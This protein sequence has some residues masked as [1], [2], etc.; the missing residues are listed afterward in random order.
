MRLFRSLEEIPPD[1][2]PSV[3]TIGNFDGVHR[4]HQWILHQV[5]NRALTLGARSVAVTFEPHPLRVLRPGQS[6]KLITPL[7]VRLALLEATGVDAV[8]LLPF[9]T[10]L[11]QM[12][13]SQFVFSIL[14]EALHSVE[15]HEGENFRF[16]HRAE[17][18]VEEL[19]ALGRKMGFAVEIQ[20][21]F[22]VAG[23][24]VSS[25][26]VRERIVSG[27]MRNARVLLGR[28]F[29]IRST[30]ARGRGIGSRLT[31]PT[32]NL[33]PYEELLP[34]H[35]VY[36]TRLTIR[37]KAFNAVTN[38]GNRPTFGEDSFSIESYLLNFEPMEL[39]GETALHLT[40]LRRLRA[41]MRFAS[42]EALKEQILRDVHRAQRYF[43]LAEKLCPD[44][45][46]E[47]ENQG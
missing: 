38:V 4:G 26:K 42:P 46:C 6:P 8:L 20:P 13:G 35:G 21:Q 36:V 33:A 24:P 27:D 34:A 22:Y 32:I 19:V 47:D 28:P 29:S 12:S 23:M 17:C 44:A 41:E 30:P 40:F 10:Q 5:R 43:G 2:G 25:S 16:G 1:F 18:G 39:T 9:T 37:D 11:S 7:Q 31:V 15:V 45:R 3:A 14:C